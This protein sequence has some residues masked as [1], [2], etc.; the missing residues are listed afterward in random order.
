MRSDGTPSCTSIL[1]V[2]DKLSEIESL[3]ADEASRPPDLSSRL[4]QVLTLMK[5]DL[6]AI[7][8]TD[9]SRVGHA[10]RSRSSDV[11]YIEGQGGLGD[12]RTLFIFYLLFRE[13]GTG[14]LS[15]EGVRR[16]A[17]TM[18][19]PAIAHDGAT[20]GAP[21]GFEQKCSYP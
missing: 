13:F 21:D 4:F 14:L 15:D 18:R 1:D 17:A 2:V 8:D 10:R 6:L 11:A 5:A 19:D 3:I 9:L 7:S 16:L 20:T 12:Q